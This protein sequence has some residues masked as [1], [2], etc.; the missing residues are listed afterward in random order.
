MDEIVHK[1]HIKFNKLDKLHADISDLNKGKNIYERIK[2]VRSIY[3]EINRN[4][5]FLARV[6]IKNKILYNSCRKI[7][8]L[9]EELNKY[10]HSNSILCQ[11]T[12]CKTVTKY[13]NLIVIY[14]GAMN[15]LFSIK[16]KNHIINYII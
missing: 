2:V 11:K 10:D 5:D 13:I 4:F 9:F 3:L 8:Y 1:L 6:K 16:I 15:N 7:P 14:H 12:I